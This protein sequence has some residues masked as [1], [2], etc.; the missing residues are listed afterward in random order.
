MAQ[1]HR[2]V[3]GG[4]V[5]APRRAARANTALTRILAAYASFS[6]AAFGIW[7][8]MLV[9]GDAVYGAAGATAMV[10]AQLLPS[11][12]LA[13]Y[14]GALADRIAPGRVLRSGYLAQAVLFGAMGANIALGGPPPVI[15]LLAAGATV[16]LD[17]AR[18]AQ[19]ALFPEV[20]RSASELT[21]ANVVSGWIDGGAYL[22]G[23]AIAG[24]AIALGGVGSAL[25][26]A[27]VADLAAAL[28]VWSGGRAATRHEEVA[29]D[30]DGRSV[31]DTLCATFS[32]P[33]T[34]LL[35]V[36]TGF[37]YLMIGALDVLCVLLAV[38][39]FHLGRGAA[40]YLNAAIGAGAT[41]AGVATFALAGHPRLVRLSVTS[42][43]AAVVALALLAAFPSVGAAVVLF[44]VIGC[45]GTVFLTVSRTLL[46][47]V[48]P[49]DAT[50]ATFA[51]IEAVT[52]LG[53]AAGAV[54]VQA[55]IAAGGVRAAI[56]AP[57]AVG[58]VVIALGWWRLRTAEHTATVPQVEIR[59]LRQIPLFSPLATPVLEDLARRLEPVAIPAGTTV[60]AEGDVGDRYY[61][62]ADGQLLV[63]RGGTM[64]RTLG[65]GSGFGEIAL[66][67]RSPRTATVTAG[68]DAL[69]YGLD[70]EA[71]LGVLTGQVRSRAA[72][73]R[74]IVSYNDPA[75]AGDRVPDGDGDARPAG[76]LEP[77]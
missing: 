76:A 58:V 73:Q 37:Y 9:Y 75:L 43:L 34:R 2:D 64:L 74:V 21:T 40:G 69:L 61:A 35:L 1:Y 51:A 45:S 38:S 30:G 26:V 42:L 67:R 65:R 22:A 25:A 53:L 46:Q 11:V 32:E 62:I 49:A 50:G 4:P 15:Y 39:T 33:A 52:S 68:T 56:V 41:L 55:G 14:A 48:A 23:P 5:D 3:D 13:P 6:V 18:P 7:I 59:L 8:A 24:L 36:L 16:A 17:V 19:A 63:T 31:L 28:L 70:Q 60:V 20:A 77:T 12:V 71:F 27:A 10:L 44:V 47:R 57:A 66:L 72:A 54:V 29:R